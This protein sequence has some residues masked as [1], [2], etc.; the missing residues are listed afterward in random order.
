MYGNS[1]GHM[2]KAL[3]SPICTIHYIAL[4]IGVTRQ[5]HRLYI[6]VSISRHRSGVAREPEYRI[7]ASMVL[8]GHFDREAASVPNELH[9]AG[10]AFRHENFWSWGV[11]EEKWRRERIARNSPCARTELA[12][13]S[14]AHQ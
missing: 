1:R 11:K 14:R 4:G 8:F 9:G 3:A 2:G 10:K 13:L 5:I 12:S 6:Q 7:P